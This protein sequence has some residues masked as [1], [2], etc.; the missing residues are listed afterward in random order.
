MEGENGETVGMDD[1]RAESIEQGQGDNK[2]PSDNN[3]DHD[4]ANNS[5]K[6]QKTNNE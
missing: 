1:V 4:S 2:G 6:V 5:E 3:S